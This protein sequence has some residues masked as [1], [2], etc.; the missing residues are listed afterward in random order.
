MNL[1][2]YT[3]EALQE[4]LKRREKQRITIP[5]RLPNADF[6][7][8]V[9]AIEN[10]LAEMVQKGY[11]DEDLEEFVFESACIAIYGPDFFTWYNKIL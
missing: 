8:M 4:E 1:K 7:K 9:E 6:T 11:E 10:G 5:P 3:E 2:D